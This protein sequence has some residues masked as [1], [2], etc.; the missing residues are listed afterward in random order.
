MTDT[1]PHRTRLA[2]RRPRSL[3]RRT[4]TPE[5]GRTPHGLRPP[6]RRASETVVRKTPSFRRRA[7]ETREGASA[8]LRNAGVGRRRR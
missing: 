8:W 3:R 2:S 7:E 6:A 1:F 4:R 5:M